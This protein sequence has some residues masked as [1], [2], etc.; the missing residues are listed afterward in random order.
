MP[1]GRSI[2]RCLSVSDLRSRVEPVN[3]LDVGPVS[4]TNSQLP[5]PSHTMSGHGRR[6]Q[7]AAAAAATAAPVPAAAA[8]EPSRKRRRS[9]SVASSS[10]KLR[11]DGSSTVTSARGRKKTERCHCPE[12]GGKSMPCHIALKHR[13]AMAA[14]AAAAE[15]PGPRR[16]VKRAKHSVDEDEDAGSHDFAFDADSEIHEMPPMG[17]TQGGGRKDGTQREAS[18]D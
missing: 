6:Q 3:E 7:A 17:Q 1:G 16:S 5:A 2:L 15:V 9:S 10:S 8:A 14:D 11:R 4:D 13:K 18:C 12:C